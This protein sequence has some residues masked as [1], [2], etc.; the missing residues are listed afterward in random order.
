MVVN[1]TFGLVETML[2]GLKSWKKCLHNFVWLEP[3]ISNLSKQHHKTCL[4]LKMTSYAYSQDWIRSVISICCFNTQE[5]IP[6]ARQMWH[7]L[8]SIRFRSCQVL[9]SRSTRQRLTWS[10]E[11]LLRCQPGGDFLVQWR[12]RQNW[13]TEFDMFD[14]WCVVGC[15]T[16]V[17]RWVEVLFLNNTSQ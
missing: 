16:Y 4:G 15:W 14:L 13:S 10:G 3:C 11:R 1:T 7:A 2:Q 17:Q 8:F 6:F 5:S 12:L 9:G